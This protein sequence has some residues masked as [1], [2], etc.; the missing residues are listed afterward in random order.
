MKTEP[1]LTIIPS[2]LPHDDV[3]IIGNKAGLQY[4]HDLLGV[5]IRNSRSDNK[6]VCCSQPDC[7]F[8]TDGEGY[9]ITVVSKPDLKLG[10]APGPVY[11]D[12]VYNQDEEIP[13]WL[14]DILREHYKE[15]KQ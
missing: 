9:R 14:D 4:L 1:I 15:E 12:S 11:L 10:D 8:P 13:E 6:P 7:F 3:V 5:A 2:A